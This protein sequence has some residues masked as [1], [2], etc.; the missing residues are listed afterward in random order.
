MES[1]EI[2]RVLYE[3][4]QEYRT[5]F[6]QHRTLEDRLSELSSR[7]YLSDSEKVEEVDLKK[8]KLVLKDRMQQLV[9]NHS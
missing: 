8:K 1:S 6:E 7:L 4:S 9:K 2:S 3:Q 5:L